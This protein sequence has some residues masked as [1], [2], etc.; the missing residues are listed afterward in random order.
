MI[1]KLF[2]GGYFYN[3][4]EIYEEV[5]AG[6]RMPSQKHTLLIFFNNTSFKKSIWHY[7]NK[8]FDLNAFLQATFAEIE[9]NSLPDLIKLS[10]WTGSYCVY[11]EVIEITYNGTVPYREVYT[12]LS[13]TVLL[14]SN[15]NEFRV[16]KSIR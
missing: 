5:H 13:P 9:Q 3:I 7:M 14:D 11:D 4:G 15:L 16:L 12:V 6:L 2:E 1:T 10:Y 8:P